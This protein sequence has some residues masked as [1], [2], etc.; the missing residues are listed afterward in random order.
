MRAL[1]VNLKQF[2]LRP[3]F[4]FLIGVFWLFVLAMVSSMSRDRIDSRPDSG[5]FGFTI[6]FFSWV[7]AFY[8]G[9]MVNEIMTRPFG[10]V[11]P[12]HCRAIRMTLFLMGLGF[13]VFPALLLLLYP[14]LD[15]MGYIRVFVSALFAGLTIFWLV[16]AG[17][18]SR[19]VGI[20]IIVGF[21]IWMT[22]G[23]RLQ[24]IEQFVVRGVLD[25]SW[26]TIGA[27]LAVSWIAWI[28]LGRDDLLR[29]HGRRNWGKIPSVFAKG[30]RWRYA[31]QK[32]RRRPIRLGWISALSDRFF[33]QRM[34][35]CVQ[36]SSTRFL[37]GQLY[38]ALTPSAWGVQNTGLAF[39]AIPIL[40]LAFGYVGD[41]F[42]IPFSFSCLLF[43]R[44]VLP[45]YSHL[46]V[47][48]GRWERFIATLT[49]T[50]VTALLITVLTVGFALLTIPLERI[51]PS[52]TLHNDPWSY[53]AV[54]LRFWYGAL[55]IL[56][57]THTLLI[58]LPEIWIILGILGVIIIPF[59]MAVTDKISIGT[60]FILAT[61]SIAV[62]WWIFILISRMVC[63][64]WSL[65]RT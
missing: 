45:A 59:I 28:L 24:A 16:L 35:S 13:S 48:G 57:L 50:A 23:G 6:I 15:T 3:S 43:M 9:M 34:A 27:G 39:V 42:A 38:L 26:A 60:E 31:C 32:N 64:K 49:N 25:Y 62:S 47:V 12:G 1:T 58:L 22:V 63:R 20:W 54:S 4:L 61:V 53:H 10:F 46:I 36:H 30:D 19:K 56:P 37:W 17:S 41:E 8:A 29:E 51:M 55:L 65:V 40:I 14:G 11:L 21:C 5:W 33:L 18:M 52:F 7:V 2:I 44:P